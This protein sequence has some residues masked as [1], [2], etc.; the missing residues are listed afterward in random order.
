[1]AQKG[2]FS[3]MN[4]L[5][6]QIHKFSLNHFTQDPGEMNNDLLQEEDKVPA[7]GIWSEII[8]RQLPQAFKA[9]LQII[10]IQLQGC[11]LLGLSFH[12]EPLRMPRG[13]EWIT[14][15]TE[16]F[17]EEWGQKQRRKVSP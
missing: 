7:T 3:C 14:M 13:R 12:N 16:A 2:D 9:F 11:Q 4:P 15:D 17:P 8:L 5:R 6:T 1:M 10:I